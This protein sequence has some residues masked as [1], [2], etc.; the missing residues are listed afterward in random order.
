MPPNEPSVQPYATTATHQTYYVVAG[1]LST[2]DGSGIVHGC[3]M[4]LASAEDPTEACDIARNA[5]EEGLAPIAAFDR[6]GLLAM[7]DTLERHPLQ[8]GQAYNLD[9]GMTEAEM[10]VHLAE[11]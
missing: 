2:Y 1:E 8:P 11:E 4:V 10:A 3:Q 6:A 5:L 7:V 9:F